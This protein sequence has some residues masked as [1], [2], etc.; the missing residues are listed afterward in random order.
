MNHKPQALP[1]KQQSISLDA[2][3]VRAELEEAPE[4]HGFTAHSAELIAKADDE[5]I[6]A[7]INIE[8]DDEFWSQYDDVRRRAITRLAD[9]LGIERD[10]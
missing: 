10:A 5:D 1:L 3:S 6:L 9:S 2:E 4:S 8:V 7:A